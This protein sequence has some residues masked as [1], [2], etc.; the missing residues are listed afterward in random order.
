VRR[1]GQTRGI[2][3]GDTLPASDGLTRLLGRDE[4][5]AGLGAPDL[6]ASA[7]EFMDNRL[8]PG[9]PDNVALVILRD[10]EG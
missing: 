1:E 5:P 4:F 2:R 3:P 8:A 10:I 7:D 6:R 9:T